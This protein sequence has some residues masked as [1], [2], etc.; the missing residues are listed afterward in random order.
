V[1]VEAGGDARRSAQD[2]QRSG[3]AVHDDVGHGKVDWIAS[4]L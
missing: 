2:H 1:D 4:V 3:H